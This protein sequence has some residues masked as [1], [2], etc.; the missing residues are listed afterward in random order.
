MYAALS[1]KSRMVDDV[2]G[3]ARETGTLGKCPT[4]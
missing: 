3:E 4:P 1:E 2:M